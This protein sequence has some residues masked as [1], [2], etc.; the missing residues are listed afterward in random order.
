MRTGCNCIGKCVITMVIAGMLWF[1]SIIS[2]YMAVTTY[3]DHSMY[4]N[5][6]T[7][8]SVFACVNLGHLISYIT[9]S[10][11]MD[12]TSTSMFPVSVLP[13]TLLRVLLCFSGVY[14]TRVQT[15][16]MWYYIHGQYIESYRLAFLTVLFQYLFFTPVLVSSIIFW[17]QQSPPVLYIPIMFI[18]PVTVILTNLT[19]GIYKKCRERSQFIQL[20]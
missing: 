19:V 1:P 6:I 7:L 13:F 16:K 10:L 5:Y 15:C 17:Y 18:G 12:N 20:Q 2:I 11:I 8:Q 9:N 4:V 3:T 14:Y